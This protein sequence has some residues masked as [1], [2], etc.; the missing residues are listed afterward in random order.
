MGMTFS[1][2]IYIHCNAPRLLQSGIFRIP[3][4]DRYWGEDVRVEATSEWLKIHRCGRRISEL[5]LTG[6]VERIVESGLVAYI[7]L[8]CID[9]TSTLDVVSAGVLI[10]REEQ[11]VWELKD[12]T[13]YP[14]RNQAEGVVLKKLWDELR[15]SKEYID[16]RYFRQLPE[17]VQRWARMLEH[18][19]LEVMYLEEADLERPQEDSDCAASELEELLRRMDHPVRNAADPPHNRRSTDRPI[20]GQLGGM[21]RR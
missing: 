4:Q 1:Q 3:S 19:D 11:E 12:W 6:E 15:P 5:R 18:L 10:H 20:E 8:D 2:S 14:G 7:D 16:A 13:E 21:R 9:G 17:R